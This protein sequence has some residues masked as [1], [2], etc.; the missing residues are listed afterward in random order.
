[1]RGALF[2][3]L[4]CLG[5]DRVLGLDDR[6]PP[7]RPVPS[8]PPCLGPGEKLVLP[9]VA[10]TYLDPA[11]E[12]PRGDSSVV[13]VG[14]GRTA[15][16]RFA[17]GANA[18]QELSVTLLHADAALAC[19]S[20]DVCTS[21]TPGIEGELVMHLMRPDWDEATATYVQRTQSE[22]W[23]TP[24]AAG[25]DR[26]AALCTTTSFDGIDASCKLT[27]APTDVAWPGDISVQIRAQATAT[28]VFGSREGVARCET[29]V[30]RA[31]ATCRR[32][33]SCG[34]GVIDTGE[35]CDDGN[36]I[37]GDTCSDACTVETTMPV[38]GNGSIE[39]GEQCDDGDTTPGDG[40]SATCTIEPRCGN[41]QV[42]NN[43]ECDDGNLN[44]FDLCTN[45]CECYGPQCTTKF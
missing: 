36:L 21:C 24:G 43:E 7:P 41:G 8:A 20:G 2:A 44:N 6:V 26:S 32:V 35:G 5:C 18:L 34:N 22:P 16:F 42:E 33:A 39:T 45:A 40:C 10:D 38:C 3:L 28:G 27:F 25:V 37:P 17:V 14:D 11:D 13:H 23:T 15:L 4:G 12:T 19:G 1:M 31:I 30:A 9:L 29:P